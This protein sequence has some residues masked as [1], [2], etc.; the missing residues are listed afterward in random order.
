MKYG[1]NTDGSFT[2]GNAG[3]P[4]G[5]RNKATVA[6]ESGIKIGKLHFSVVM[7]YQCHLAIF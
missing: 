3:K 7:D 4:R 6:I 2:S 5:S 1:R